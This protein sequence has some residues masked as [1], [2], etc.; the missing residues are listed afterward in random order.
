[1]NKYFLTLLFLSVFL[2]VNS[3]VVPFDQAKE[4]ARLFFVN[5]ENQ[6]NKLKSATTV[7]V[8]SFRTFTTGSATL[9][10]SAGMDNEPAFYI[11]NRT[12][13]PGFVIVS[14]KKKSGKLSP[15]LI[16][17]HFVKSLLSN[18]YYSTSM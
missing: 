13:T 11:F 8:D 2:Q 12:D 7:T 16:K 17:P 1:M 15:G 10:K 18:K 5:N 3:Q 6:K 4:K 9:L 14:E